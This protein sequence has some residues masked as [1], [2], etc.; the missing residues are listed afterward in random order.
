MTR[1]LVGLLAATLVA[2]AACQRERAPTTPKASG[3]VEATEIKIASKVPGRVGRGARHR[4]RPR[5]G[6]PG[7]RDDPDDR[8]GSRDRARAGRSRAG[9]G[10][11]PAAPGRHASRGHSTGGSAGRRG[12]RRQARGGRGTVG[13]AR[14]RSAVRAAP[15]QPRRLAEA[16][17]RRR[18]PPAAGGSAPARHRRS[19][20][21]RE[22]RRSR[23]SK[24]ARGPRRS[25]RRRRAW[26]PSTRRSRR[27]S[28][29]AR[30]P[31]IIAPT[32][33]VVTSRLVEPGELV[34]V[35]TPL[36]VIV[37]LD[38]AWADAYVEE[39]L[40]PGLRIDQAGDGHH[41][42]AAIVWPGASPSSRRAQSS[43]R[44]TSRRP[45]E[46]AKLVYRV[47][48]TVDN[49]QGDAQ[50]GHAGRGRARERRTAGRA[51]MTGPERAVEFVDVRKSFGATKAVDGLT[52][53]R[54]R[55]ARCSASSVRTAPAR[56]R[57][58][59]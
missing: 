49:R 48:V 31:T 25:T 22:R 14:R 37:D 34:A 58:C 8:H 11:A 16:A 23:G 20:A 5:R 15:A 40:V 52:L 33:G 56:R 28:T 24:P 6:R 17:R 43:R 39:P 35:G 36:I 30:K 45:S 19:R 59:G 7:A 41:R 57:R 26:R 12:D 9:A 53:R 3:Y 42:R 54:R 1:M 32:D 10:T 29:I 4:G 2:S 51:A 18:L 44:A 38:H 47:K 27:S 50:A 55:A 46:R 13:R 21:R